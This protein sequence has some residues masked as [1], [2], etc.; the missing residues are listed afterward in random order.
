MARELHASDP[1]VERPYPV[2]PELEQVVLRNMLNDAAEAIYFKDLQSRFIAVSRA[3][4]TLHGREPEEL[5]GLTDFDLFTPEHAGAA[6]AD[7][8]RV[9]A[10]GVPLLNKEEKETWPDRGD[11][12]VTSNKRPLRDLD[13]VIIGTFGLSRDI[14]RRV[15]AEQDATRAAD[16]LALTHAELGRVE[17]QLRTVLDTSSDG[18]ALYDTQ[19]RYQYLNA[20]ARRA[21]EDPYWDF[22]GR[23]DRELGR[24]EAFLAVWEASLKSVLSTGENRSVDFSLGSGRDLRWFA[25]QL[26]AQRETQ[27]GPPI[28]VVASTRE[29]TELKRAQ[30]KLAHQAVHDPLTG[31]AN[32][33]LLTDRLTRA[34]LRM[35]RQPGRIALL[36][37]DL[38]HFKDVNDAHG[39]EAGD[40]IL[41]EVGERLTEIARR[42]DTVA[43]FGG[44]EF[45]LLCDKL[46]TDDDVRVVA[47]RVVRGIAEP[48]VVNGG[49]ALHVTAS[50][51][52]VMTC[53]PYATSESLVRDADAAMYQAKERGR[54]HFQFFDAGIRDLAAAK[55]ATE[56]D[57]SH[58]LERGQF[59]LEYQPVFNLSGRRYIVGAEALIRW[60]HPDRGTVPPTEFIGIAESRGL[61]VPIGTWVLNEACRQ[62]V[63]W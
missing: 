51:G 9:I 8:Q 34:L 3:L 21:A 16:E 2:G 50:V 59:R 17:A 33:V 6:Y 37:V 14:T 24:D 29:V 36:F 40:R 28:G 32:R 23:T 4:A 56:N 18:I 41:V 48:F 1:A 43:R 49:A 61:I 31:L 7:E 26:S 57:L 62:L 22:L 55:N 46:N 42:I 20:A 44:D 10:T 52:V 13:G 5:L 12:W 60:D 47:D 38:D 11:T 54:N 15:T 19:L 45:V 30:S 53:D 58:A 35:E 39:H 27:H 63:E 25:A